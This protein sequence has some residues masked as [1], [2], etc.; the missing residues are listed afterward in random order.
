M[1][2]LKLSKLSG[3][4]N[5]NGES[6]VMLQN[7]LSE[8]RKTLDSKLSESAQMMQRQFGQ[9]A[10][11]ITDV[12]ERLTKLDETNKQ[13][14][15]FSDQ[16][17][18]LQDILKNPKQRG[19]FG[20]YYLETLL[21]NA[22]QPKQ[23]Q[24]QYKFKDGEIVDAVLFMGEKIIPID[25]KFSLENYNRIVEEKDSAKHKELETAFKN[26]LK[27]RIDETAKYIRPQEDTTEFAFMFIP[28]E[29]IYYDLLVNK[30]GAIKVNTRDLIDYAISEKKVHIVSPTTF[31]VTLQS[32]WQGMRAYEIQESTKE[33]LKNVGLLSRHIRSYEDYMKKLGTHLGTTVNA[34]NSAY[35]E[36]AKID[37][38]VVKLTGGE[39]SVDPVQ[40]DKPAVE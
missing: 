31:Y 32:M 36:F 37:K 21:K 27:K 9:S 34:Y 2:F 16:L 1:V 8:M 20:E 40:L 7:Q 17:Q 14:L 30:V 3:P 23:Y 38:D 11:I 24:M 4:R 6:L 29:G 26:D 18:N 12:A 28:A 25:S 10:K 5:D 35:K 15:N 13:V 22:F 19:I 33:I 39:K